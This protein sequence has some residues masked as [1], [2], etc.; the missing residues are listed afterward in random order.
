M[1]LFLGVLGI[2]WPRASLSMPNRMLLLVIPSFMLAVFSLAY[3]NPRYWTLALPVL[4]ILAAI[5]LE[6]IAREIIARS[7]RVAPE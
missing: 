7:R 5:P 1:V 6:A 2:F 4:S 3:P